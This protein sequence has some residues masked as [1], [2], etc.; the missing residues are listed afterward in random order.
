MGTTGRVLDHIERGNIDFSAMRTIVLDE[1]DQMLKLGFK[2]DVELILKTIHKQCKND[3][4]ICLFSATVPSWVREVARQHMK[5]NLRVIDLCQDLKNKT[6]RNVQ[7]LAISCPYQN[8]IAALA[9]ILVCY[10]GNTGKTIVFTQTKADANALIL[11]DKIKQDIE[12][13]HGDI[14][15]NQREVTMKRFK[16]G[17]FRVLCATDVASR[18][19]DIPNVDLVIQIEPPKEA[20]TY[21]HRA[22]RT[23][24]AGASGTCITFYT[25]KTKYLIED[26]ELQAGIKLQRIGVP[27]PEDVIRASATGILKS[28]E[29]VNEKVIPLF[30]DSS[31][32]LI[33][34]CNGDA[35]KALSMALAFISGHYKTALKARSL[36]TGAEHMLTLKMESIVNGRLSAQSVFQI[37][38]RY[39]P[40]QM[41]D[42]VRS[43][44]GMR[45]GHGAVFDIYEDQYQRFMDNFEHLQDQEGDRLDFTVDRCQ[46]LP[47][48]VE[49][50]ESSSGWRNEGADHGGSGGYAGNSYGSRGGGSRGGGRGFRGGG[51]YGG[52]DY[53]SGGGR[54]RGGGYQ[55]RGGY[56]GGGGDNWGGGQPWRTQNSSSGYENQRGSRGGFGGRGG[57]KQDD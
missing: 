41:A 39:W 35:R 18:G 27:Q 53:R 54:G 46:D 16:E 50:G 26:I 3:V 20:E 28:L 48:I 9:D 7:H 43:M 34:Q 5:K 6:A 44:R 22:G 38:K 29:E 8:R 19:L 10:G 25:N 31:N 11:T 36:I 23:A 51:G 17:K 37:L 45:N 55:E 42:G 13:M 40:P 57:F 30:H 32:Q 24:R 12:V 21:I 1:A 49:E 4:Q 52:D 33:A 2:E 47:D 15:Q 56:S 14:A